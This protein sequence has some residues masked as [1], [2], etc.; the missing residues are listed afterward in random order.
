MCD[1]NP[2]TSL[3]DPFGTTDVHPPDAGAVAGQAGNLV[4]TEAALQPL[5]F[6]TQQQYQPQ[7]TGLTLDSIMRAAYGQNGQPG[8]AGIF[9]GIMPQLSQGVNAANSYSRAGQIGDVG[10]LGPAAGQ[11]VRG[12]N[13]GQTQTLDA[14]R[15]SALSGLAAGSQ[16]GPEDAYRIT[17]GVRNDWAS[18]GLGA[19]SP[20]QLDEA[21]KLFG[22][23]QQLLGQRQQFGA[24]EAGLENS[25]VTSPAL[26]FLTGQSIS[27]ALGTSLLGQ[28][29]AI[30]GPSGP[31]LTHPSDAL[32]A[33]YNAIAASQMGT[34]NNQAAL[35]G[36]ALSY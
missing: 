36:G 27:P 13:P 19:S 5:A 24:Q 29:G 16:V 17:S 8:L 25:L 26:G 7:Y 4:R 33:A 3:L 15:D 11:A 12:I 31:S 34:A 18:R 20:A 1:F 21:L 2:I 32:G 14:L 35:I 23:G 30:A 22:G 28:A 9:S 10:A 6:Q